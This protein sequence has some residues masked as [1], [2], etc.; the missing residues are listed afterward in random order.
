MTSAQVGSLKPHHQDARQNKA[1]IRAT[2]A[3][4]VK[5]LIVLVLVEAKDIATIL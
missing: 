2:T 4:H 1:A 5:T 3:I